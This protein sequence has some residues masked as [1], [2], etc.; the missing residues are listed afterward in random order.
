M[1]I[2]IQVLYCMAMGIQFLDESLKN[3]GELTAL[4]LLTK[5]IVGGIPKKAK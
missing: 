3:S 4:E 1:E 5:N 2:I